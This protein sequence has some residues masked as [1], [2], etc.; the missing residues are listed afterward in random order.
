MLSTLLEFSDS[1]LESEL[2]LEEVL[3]DIENDEDEISQVESKS[4]HEDDDLD[5]ETD[6]DDFDF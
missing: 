1:L 3:N 2:E 5:Y 6:S 4:C